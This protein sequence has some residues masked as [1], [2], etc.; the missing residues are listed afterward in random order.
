MDLVEKF[1][2]NQNEKDDDISISKADPL[3]EG[4]ANGAITIMLYTGYYRIL[5]RNELSQR[6]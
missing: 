6:S 1:K 3:K 4:R 5:Q 2:N